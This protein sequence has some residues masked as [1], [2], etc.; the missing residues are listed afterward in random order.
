[1]GGARE[2][3]RREYWDQGL[4]P[5]EWADEEE[6]G[7]EAGERMGGPRMGPGSAAGVFSRLQ[8][9]LGLPNVMKT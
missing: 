8:R 6:E 1:M 3:Q 7:Q 2:K 4:R 9:F 5:L